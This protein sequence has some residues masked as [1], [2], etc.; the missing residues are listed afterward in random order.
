[1][2]RG[3][4]N[5][6]LDH[7]SLSRDE[8]CIHPAAEPAYWFYRRFQAPSPMKA[9]LGTAVTPIVPPV[10]YAQ[11]AEGRYPLVS[12]FA[13]LQFLCDTDKVECLYRPADD[14]SH[15][16]IC[17]IA[18]RSVLSYE[19]FQDS[20]PETLVAKF[21]HLESELPARLIPE[22]LPLDPKTGR[23]TKMTVSSFARA[24][25]TT[26]STF[27]NFLPRLRN[28]GITDVRI[29]DVFNKKEKKNHG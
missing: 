14:I 12:D 20:Q 28:G 10:V 18:W 25:G 19:R 1:M 15:K 7:V 3:L 5:T 16:Q 21:L 2:T 27:N 29:E 22:L 8:V 24:C 17:D 26:A 13:I 11:K 9:G 4:K 23:P 6:R